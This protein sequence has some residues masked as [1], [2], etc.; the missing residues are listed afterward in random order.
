MCLARK[1]KDREVSS[2]TEGRQ[3]FCFEF[4]SALKGLTHGTWPNS[5]ANVVQ[6]ISNEIPLPVTIDISVYL[7]KSSIN[8]IQSF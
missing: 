1:A 6:K 3:F 5:V 7:K 2:S 4:K 8:A